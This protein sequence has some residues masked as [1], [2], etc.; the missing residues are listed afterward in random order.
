MIAGLQV[1]ELPRTFRDAIQITKAL[2]YQYLWIDSLCIM[3]DDD[4]DWRTEAA[5]MR[6]IYRHSTCNLAADRN[7]WQYFQ[8]KDP[9]ITSEFGLARSSSAQPLFCKVNIAWLGDA[10]YVIVDTQLWNDYVSIAPLESRAWVFQERL[11]APRVLHI[12]T[13]QFFWDCFQHRACESFPAGFPQGF[14]NENHKRMLPL[15]PAMPDPQFPHEF[16]PNGLQQL[17]KIYS[18]WGGVVTAYMTCSLTRTED[19]LVALSGVAKQFQSDLAQDKY[20]AGLW[21]QRLPVDLLWN[22]VDCCT[23]DG[24]PSSRPEPYIAPTWS[25]ASIEGA[26]SHGFY[27]FQLLR[28]DALLIEILD[29]GTTPLS[30]DETGQIIDG[31]I[32]LQGILL[33]ISLDRINRTGGGGNI[34]MMSTVFEAAIYPDIAPERGPDVSLDE[35]ANVVPD[36]AEETFLAEAIN[37]SAKPLYFLPVAIEWI[38]EDEDPCL[39]G[40]LLE[41]QQKTRTTEFTRFGTIKLYSAKACHLIGLE[42]NMDTEAAHIASGVELREIVLV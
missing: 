36:N 25:W 16:G 18:D 31:F 10:E 28:P 39:T 21:R 30:A 4:A 11:L 32:K 9:P 3:Q 34:N 37:L 35:I 22:V 26:I 29:A 27:Q 8:T 6:N 2:G 12:S 19:K 38:A 42:L 33:K 5:E 41:P 23:A 24:H 15:L 13:E 1:A 40:I 7:S 20:L 17:D 14:N